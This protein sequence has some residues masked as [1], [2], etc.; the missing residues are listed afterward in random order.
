LSKSIEPE[1]PLWQLS[2]QSFEAS[3]PATGAALPLSECSDAA[4]QALAMQALHVKRRTARK[5]AA[6]A[7]SPATKRPS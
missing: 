5:P 7:A 2:V 3:K 6:G 4:M 1:Q